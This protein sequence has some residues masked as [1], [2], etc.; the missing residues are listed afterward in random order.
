[1][2]YNVKTVG[3]RIEHQ[4]FNNSVPEGV[5]SKCPAIP[6]LSAFTS[7]CGDKILSQ[8][9]THKTIRPMLEGSYDLG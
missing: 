5:P 6:E 2:S 7:K 1:M 3:D 8:C 4:L 9:K